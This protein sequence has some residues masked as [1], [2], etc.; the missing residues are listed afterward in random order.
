MEQPFTS[1][2]SDRAMHVRRWAATLLIAAG[3]ALIAPAAAGATPI[4]FPF[5]S[6][7]QGWGV[8]QS[9]T[10]TAAPFIATGGNP[11]GFIRYTD[12]IAETGC[13]SAAP[14]DRSFLYV[15]MSPLTGNYG[16][17]W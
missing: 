11:G 9:N 16:G 10:A 8:G 12:A 1:G 3:A 2:R 6:S 7:S 13:P 4:S 5:D 15:T 17:S 14:C